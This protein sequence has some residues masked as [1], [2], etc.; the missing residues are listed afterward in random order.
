M[1]TNT[2]VTPSS[3][4]SPARAHLPELQWV[5]H[6]GWVACDPHAAAGDP[7]R[8][9]AYLE[10]KDA[11]VYVLWLHHSGGVTEYASLRDALDA[12]AVPA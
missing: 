1:G 10:C 11:R 8:V 6:G 5:G 2:A 12:L 9:L 3:S 7:H 4:S